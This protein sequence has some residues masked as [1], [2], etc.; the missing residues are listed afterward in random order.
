M[1]LEV[2]ITRCVA[3]VSPILQVRH[4]NSDF[5]PKPVHKYVRTGPIRSCTKGFGWGNVIVI[6]IRVLHT[7]I[8]VVSQ[9][10]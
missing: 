3:L 9:H 1:Y 5:G 8:F 6:D 2:D 7:P 10:H 4:E